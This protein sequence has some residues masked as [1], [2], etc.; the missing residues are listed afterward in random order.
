VKSAILV[1]SAVE[2]PDI[3]ASLDSSDHA[4]DSWPNE[5]ADSVFGLDRF[6]FLVRVDVRRTTVSIVR[7]L[8]WRGVPVTQV[9]V[10]TRDFEDADGA[11]D[12][13]ETLIAHEADLGHWNIGAMV[14]GACWL[15]RR[16]EPLV[17]EFAESRE[18]ARAL[19]LK[20]EAEAKQKAEDEANEATVITA[21]FQKR[22]DRYLVTLQ[23]GILDSGEFW[24]I[25]FDESWERERFWDWLQWNTERFDEFHDYMQSGERIAL[26]RQLLRE[27]LTTEQAVKK[28]GLGSGGR[29]PLRFW[30][31]ES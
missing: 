16:L 29:R 23:R 18:G 25:G 11:N 5:T 9:V 12:A 22:K 27:M 8:E 1:D 28:L 24:T 4:N 19:Q 20:Q 21:Y 17:M 14:F 10:W 2:P 7:A 30:R 26:E 3:P 6:D 31:G 15:E 13:Y